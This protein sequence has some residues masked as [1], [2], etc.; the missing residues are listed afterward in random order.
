LLGQFIGKKGRE[1]LSAPRKSAPRKSAP[2]KSAPRKS[3]PRKSALNLRGLPGLIG[4]PRY[5]TPGLPVLT[6]FGQ[7]LRDPNFEAQDSEAKAPTIESDNKLNK[8]NLNIFGSHGLLPRH[9][10]RFLLLSNFRYTRRAIQTLSDS[11]P[12]DLEMIIWGLLKI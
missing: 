11:Q 8:N 4:K 5:T 9:S 12:R 2:R 3:A 7:I 1:S 10:V 6:P